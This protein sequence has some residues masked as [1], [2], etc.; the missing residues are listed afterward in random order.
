MTES[1]LAL[2]LLL[3]W[4]TLVGMDLVSV[5]Q[6]M[7]A[8]PIV[9]GGVAG[10]ILGDAEA[11]LRLGA[12]IE[13]FAL[14]VLPIGASRY[15]DYGPPTVGLTLLLVGRPWSDALGLAGAAVLVLSV[16]GGWTLVRL[17][18]ANAAAIQRRAAAL[19]AAESGTVETL[20]YGGL[21][22]DAV[23]SLAG[24][25]AAMVAALALRALPPVLDAAT[26]GWLL[27]VLVGT[28]TGAAIHGALRSAGRGP[29]LTRL[30]VGVGAGA[31]LAGLA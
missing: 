17:R 29:R 31:L 27:V 19:A 25:A 20:Q 1:P 8:R 5:P 16:V 2:A 3:A 15:P 6:A 21:A 18:H 12:L 10:V 14:D 13:L 11:G 23:R 26:T 4:G 9:A 30:A 24:T 7:F 28:G 22:R